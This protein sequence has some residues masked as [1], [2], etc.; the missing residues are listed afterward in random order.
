MNGI[1]DFRKSDI[2]SG[3][4]TLASFSRP[5][6]VDLELGSGSRMLEFGRVPIR[7]ISMRFHL[8]REL[9]AMLGRH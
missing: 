9:Q 7:Y 3:D 4:S 6:S 5:S 2:I 1:V 8:R